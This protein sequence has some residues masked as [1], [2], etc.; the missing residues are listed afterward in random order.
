MQ[1]REIVTQ[2]D[3]ITACDK[4]VIEKESLAKANDHTVSD[5]TKEVIKQ[6]IIEKMKSSE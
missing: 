3:L 4:I 2:N 6:A 1:E 5:K